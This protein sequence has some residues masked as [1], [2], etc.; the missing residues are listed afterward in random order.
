MKK[1][2][3]KIKRYPIK[4]IVYILL[5]LIIARYLFLPRTN[6][7]CTETFLENGKITSE[8]KSYPLSSNFVKSKNY[9]SSC[10]SSTSI[11]LFGK[12]Y[13]EIDNKIYYYNKKRKVETHCRF[14]DIT[15]LL[16][17]KTLWSDSTFP[18]NTTDKLF[19]RYELLDG[20]NTIDQKNFTEI[21]TGNYRYG[22]ATDGISLFYNSQKFDNAV[23]PNSFKNVQSMPIKELK[24]YYYLTVGNNVFY[25]QK[26][27]EGADAKSFVLIHTISKSRADYSQDQNSVYYKGIPLPNVDP[28]TFMMIED[29][30]SY[31]QFL[32]KDKNQVY[33]Q[34]KVI[35]NADPESFQIENKML[36]DKNHV[37]IYQDEEQSPILQKN[38]QPDIQKLDHYFSKNKT[39]AFYINK[40]I[41]NVDIETF[42]T[43]P[44][45]CVKPNNLCKGINGEICPI[46]EDLNCISKTQLNY[47]YAF[48]KDKNRLYQYSCNMKDIDP[49][50]FEWLYIGNSIHNP[51][52]AFDKNRLYEFSSCQSRD[53]SLPLIGPIIFIFSVNVPSMFFADSQQ[54]HFSTKQ[55]FYETHFCASSLQDMGYEEYLKTSGSLSR[56]QSD[57]PKAELVFEDNFFQYIFIDP[58][59]QQQYPTDEDYIIEK[60][61]GLSY[62]LFGTE[63]SP[64]EPIKNIN[65]NFI[66][67]CFYRKQ[68]L[69]LLS[70]SLSAKLRKWN[71]DIGMGNHA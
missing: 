24:D 55:Y 25:D 1:I 7:F 69:M 58:N 68:G 13:A 28:K 65:N 6:T 14:Y 51:L 21:T 2:F 45:T 47:D 60:S 66:M 44:P 29:K 40:V 18:E 53:I 36:Q 34:G 22:I 3:A 26:L 11:N 16:P 38:L 67:P 37:W 64:C 35:E 70:Y 19:F 63:E 30:E 52:I 50:S 56:I 42:N 8:K 71:L 46:S 5:A 62:P 59:R 33:W 15:C 4:R 12:H 17:I 57:I 41:E 32:S 10:N 49:D 39:Q 54:F 27:I 31:Y 61:S 43:I 23:I 48:A 9:Q 20:Q